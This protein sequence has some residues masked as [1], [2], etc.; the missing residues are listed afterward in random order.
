MDTCWITN[1]VEDIEKI[2]DLTQYNLKKEF[3]EL[4]KKI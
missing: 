2:K 4:R 3:S 1:I